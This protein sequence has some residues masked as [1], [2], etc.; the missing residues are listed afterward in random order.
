[1]A[2]G[3]G[4]PVGPSSPELSLRMTVT[5]AT[6]SATTIAPATAPNSSA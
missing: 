5:T 3:S 1:V 4:L 6:I 2:D